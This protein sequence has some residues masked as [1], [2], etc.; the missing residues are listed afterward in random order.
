MTTYWLSDFCAL[1]NSANINPFTGDSRNFRFNSL[2]RLIIVSTLVFAILF[3]SQANEIFLGGGI[4]VFLSVIIYMLT[5]NSAEMSVDDTKELKSYMDSQKLLETR[6]DNLK[7]G[8]SK[9]GEVVIED[10]KINSENEVT[11]DYSPPNM[12]LKKQMYFFEGN[13]MPSNVTATKIN[14]MDYLSLGKQVETGNAK[15]L[16]S[17]IGKNL[18]FT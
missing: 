2:T 6:E 1:F 8:L 17:L 7:K 16:H 15:Q 3:N 10:A 11:L 4:S 18:S 9:M 12:D 5:Y 14:P 13:K